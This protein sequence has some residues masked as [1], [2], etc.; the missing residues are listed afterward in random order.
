MSPGETMI[1]SRVR[2]M[3]PP[4]PGCLADLAPTS[5]SRSCRTSLRRGHRGPWG[6]HG[7]VAELMD[8]IRPPGAGRVPQQRRFQHAAPAVMTRRARKPPRKQRR[9]AERDAAKKAAAA[10][11]WGRRERV[12]PGPFPMRPSIITRR[13]PARAGGPGRRCP[14]LRGP[15]SSKEV[16]GARRPAR[17][18][19]TC[20][21]HSARA[22][23]SN[24]APR[25]P[26]VPDSAV[27][28]GRGCARSL[29][30]CWSSSTC[31]WSGACGCCPTWPWTVSA[32]FIDPARPGPRRWAAGTLEA[33]Q[34]VIIAGEVVGFDETTLRS[35]AAGEKKFVHG[36]FTGRRSPCPTLVPGRWR[37]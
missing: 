20:T 14:G 28:V 24:A 6:W 36:A 27:S 19:M 5:R 31:R 30:T 33:G 12:R 9:Q 37:P 8:R 35:G 2:K 17:S 18:S 26:G 13:A 23:V 16:P 34:D 10:N 15:T 32:G 7:Q 29:S 25:R 11:S 1:I 4:A 3:L 21:R 22:V